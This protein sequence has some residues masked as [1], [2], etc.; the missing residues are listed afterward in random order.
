MQEKNSAGGQGVFSTLTIG[1]LTLRNR[2]I[3]S[4]TNE[5]MTVGQTP[6][7]MLVKHHADISKGGAGMTTLAYCA[8]NQDGRTF[9]NQIVMNEASKPALRALTHAVH[10]GG[11]AVSA[12]LTHGG[13][14]TFLN[15]LSTRYPRSSSGGFNA[16]GILSGRFFKRAMSAEDM[17]S[18]ADDF[19]RSARLARDCGFD[20]VELHMGHGYLLSQ[21]L[22]PH[23]NRRQDA[24]GGDA[25]ARSRYPVEVL[26][27]VLDAVGQ[28][29]AVVAKICVTEGFSGGATVHDAVEV[30]KQLEAAGAHLLV[31]SGGMNVECP[32]QI[33][34]STLPAEAIGSINKPLIK[35]ATRLSMF[36]QPK[37]S[38]KP[39]YFMELSK[40]IRAVTTMPLAYL[41]GVKTFDAAEA[42]F[43]QGFDAIAMAR[44]FI[45][46]PAVVDVF[47]QRQ[48]LAGSCTSCNHCVVSMYSAGG[49]SCMLNKT[50][51][52]ALNQIPAGRLAA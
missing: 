2:F 38:F 18:V 51:Q 19:V 8:V 36:R 5:G 28:D 4:A 23:Y 25:V 34:G 11:A 35:F 30:A 13:A 27:R 12:Q 7:E 47:R 26:S 43:A 44:A 50:D 14:F 21:F 16:A 31:L 45:H 15:N 48:Q 20:A 9:E 49:T 6:S 42:A 3:K 29:V 40:Q 32:W 52:V 22:S 46:N 39:L 17:R 1:P 41:G 33:F 10:A 37:L 24:Y